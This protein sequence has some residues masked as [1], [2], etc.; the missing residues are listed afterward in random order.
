M[1]DGAAWGAPG[2]G[3]TAQT[4]TARKLHYCDECRSYSI[5]PGQEYARHVAFPGSDVNDGGAPWSLNLC[6]QH[7][8]HYGRIM[9]PRRTRA[10]PSTSET[11]R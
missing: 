11:G 9:P 4:L 3:V 5:Q 6:E 7:Q 1:G 8:T 10:T 2:V